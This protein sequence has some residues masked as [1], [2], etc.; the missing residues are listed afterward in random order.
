MNLE[1]KMQHPRPADVDGAS[2]HAAIDAI[3][4]EIIDITL[5]MYI[6]LK[7]KSND[8]FQQKQVKT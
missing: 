1:S 8:E 7:S 4:L 5:H 2:L 6:L 3:I